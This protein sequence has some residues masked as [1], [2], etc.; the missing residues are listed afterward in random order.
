M[1]G[2]WFILGTEVV[3]QDAQQEYGKLW[4]P[5]AA[6]YGVRVLRGPEAPSLQESRADTS[7]VLLVEFPTYADA[8][9]C[10]DD[11]DYAAARIFALKA[12]KRDFMIIEAE[13]GELSSI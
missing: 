10:Y 1:K 12:A 3:D 4:A 5:I 9:A 2:Y 8:K 6:K 11:S 7:R 13:F